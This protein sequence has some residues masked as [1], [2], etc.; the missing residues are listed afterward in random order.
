MHGPADFDAFT[1]KFALEYHLSDELLLYASIQEGFKSG[2]YNIGSSQLDP[3][4]PE[5]IWAYEVGVKSGLADGRV[6][7]N[8]A[9]FHYDYTNLQAQDSIA[10]QPIIRNV[11]KARVDGVELEFLALVTEWLQFDGSVSYLDAR[12]TE[13]ELTEPLRPAP[14]DQPPGSV[15]RDLDGLSLPRA[16]EW[17][18]NV[19]A[20]TFIPVGHGGDLSVR[21]DYAWQ[22]R[23]YY[24][25][26]NIDAASEDAF[27][28]LNA[29]IEYQRSGAPWSVAVHGK[30]LTDEAYFLNQILT[31]TYY[32]AEFV[33]TL[34]A[35][36]TYGLEFRW[37]L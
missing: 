2:G 32:G 28:L 12:F 25:V 1:P 11:G 17:K 7:L 26:F 29:R 24:T 20:E 5:E 19:G 27:G 33:G 16:P 13:G 21:V 34:G 31:G 36:R 18:Y 37:S 4:E 10:N 8:G 22:S 30:N 14:L 35:P 15:V 9:L 6:R 3:F 23:I